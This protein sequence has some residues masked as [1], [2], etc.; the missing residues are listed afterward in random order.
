MG[1]KEFRVDWENLQ[2]PGFSA[3]FIEDRHGRLDLDPQ[4]DFSDWLRTPA[5]DAIIRNNMPLLAYIGGKPEAFTSKDH[6]FLPGSSFVKQLIIINNSRVDV[7]CRC[8]W[9]LNLPSSING[10]E[11]VTI[12]TG[13]QERIPMKFDLP[14][15][16]L[17]GKYTIT[18]NVK[19]SNG[20]VQVD[21]FDIHVI[22]LPGE[23]KYT[24]RTALY[25]T[26][27]ETKRLL[28]ET[29]IP[30]QLVEAGADLSGYEILIIGKGSLATEGRGLNL[31]GVRDGLK[32][33][34]FEQ[35]SEV[36]EKRFG[37]RVHEQ[38][39]R[40]VHNRIADHP[41]MNGLGPDN[42]HDW[43]GSATIL[44]P[45]LKVDMN[46]RVFA[47]A[48]TVKWC[49]I[50][51]TRIWR[52]GNRGNVASVLI[53]KPA[54]GNFLPV[55]DGGYS[56]Q[57]SP[58]M[59]YREGKGMIMFCQLDVTGRTENDPAAVQLSRNLLSYLSGW[60]PGTMRKAVY[61]GD[62]EGLGHL[63]R[64]GVQVEAFADKKITDEQVLIVSTGAS[65]IFGS[66]LK[67]VRKWISAGG[68]VLAI[69]LDQQEAGALFPFSVN[70]K[71]E[72]HIAAY[73]EKTATGSLFAGINPADVHNRDP[74]EIPLVKSGAEI[75]ANGVLA[76][77]AQA[78]V[79][80][81]QLV[82]WLFDYSKE[83]HN[84]KQSFRRS[85]FLLSRLLGNLGV[86]SA[87]PLVGRFNSPPDTSKAEKR[88]LEGLY[89]DQPEEY[90]DPYRF[91]RW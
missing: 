24:G 63:K 69:G 7:T 50:T 29:G 60:K 84:V 31:A 19:F 26:K 82:P 51:V 20:E 77:A 15:S 79:V 16:L 73:F 13:R 3:D 53:E 40:I 55:I 1:R 89:L 91:F 17:P 23:V 22:P 76:K 25:D 14:A 34:V 81:C 86:E 44:P 30:Y 68:N 28:D 56:L 80:F 6:N 54:C 62:P 35:S 57:Y 78:R 72:E 61:A 70:M 64:A 58:L 83:K 52:C 18:S 48:P 2:R 66:K 5:S 75:T 32:V 67:S 4:N 49:D 43:Q 39:L 8:S 21:A 11:T 42:L 59:E 37:F 36:L 65:G 41:V 9:S 45:R 85:S 12:P 47:G 87:V 90:D 27:G 88:W 38:G 71:K 10:S 46:D 33:L 74:K